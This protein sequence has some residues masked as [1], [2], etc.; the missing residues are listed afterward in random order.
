[1]YLWKYSGILEALN[2]FLYLLMIPMASNHDYGF[3]IC[4]DTA[5]VQKCGFEFAVFYLFA[6]IMYLIESCS[7][8]FYIIYPTLTSII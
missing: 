1:M 4:G 7:V 3:E 8:M 6:T 2:N 5:D